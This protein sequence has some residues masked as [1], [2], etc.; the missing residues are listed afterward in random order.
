MTDATRLTEERLEILRLVQD[1]TIS[2]E[3]AARLLEALDRSD[4]NRNQYTEPIRMPPPPEAPRHRRSRLHRRN[5]R[6][7]VTEEGS[8]QPKLNIVLPGPLLGSGLTIVRKF[9]PDFLFDA[10]DLEE[11]VDTGAEGT[12]LDI[13]D[14]PTRVEIIAEDR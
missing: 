5:V 9:A 2:P 10:G 14:G 4:R 13:V 3:D 6:I 7:R 12:L 1:Q 8:S 11:S